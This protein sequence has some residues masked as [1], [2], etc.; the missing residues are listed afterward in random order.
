M[1]S[2]DNESTPWTEHPVDPA[3]GEDCNLGSDSESLI[4]DSDESQNDID[5]KSDILNILEGRDPETLGGLITNSV[6]ETYSQP[7]TLNPVEFKAMI[8]IGP[9]YHSTT[10]SIPTINLLGDS[11]AG[12]EC[13]SEL[14]V[15]RYRMPIYNLT[16]PLNLN[17]ANGA[18]LT[19]LGWTVVPIAFS[20]NK[21]YNVPCYVIKNLSKDLILGTN[22][23]NNY[24]A[25]LDFSS[26]T[27]TLS[28][29]SYTETIEFSLS[30]AGPSINNINIRDMPEVLYNPDVHSKY[31]RTV[32]VTEL[33]PKSETLIN[34]RIQGD[35]KYALPPDKYLVVSPIRHTSDMYY[36]AHCVSTVHDNNAVQITV[37]NPTD[38]PV[39]LDANK[40][41]AV[42]DTLIS[43]DSLTPEPPLILVL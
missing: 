8:A 32:D 1:E 17:G 5:F 14:L 29:K 11:G 31:C 36:A 13:V 42:V 35:N 9:T 24:D 7:T 33:R 4:Y 2:I 10:I 16:C 38:F 23:L 40:L 26:H 39:T 3:P 19:L 43:K 18:P 41:V 27:M 34:L 37:I 25:T 6:L 12:T 28:S 22:F 30:K 21:V 15:S 20:E